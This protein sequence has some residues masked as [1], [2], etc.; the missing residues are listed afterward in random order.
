[1]KIPNSPNPATDD[2]DENE[3][4]DAADFGD[5][6]DDFEEGG[7]DGEFGDFDDDFQEPEEVVSPP[8]QSLPSSL[9]IFVS[10]LNKLACQQNHFLH[11]L[12]LYSPC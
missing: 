1:M 10:R 2:Y 11:D 5:D 8:P 3:D 6:F 7:E 9:P 4:G 12:T